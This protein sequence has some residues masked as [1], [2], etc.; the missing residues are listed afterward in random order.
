MGYES[1]IYIIEKTKYS[2]DE[3]D[4]MKYARVLAMFTRRLGVGLF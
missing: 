2:W 4:G 3:E 1:K